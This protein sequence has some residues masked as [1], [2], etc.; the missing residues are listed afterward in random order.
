M[1]QSAISKMRAAKAV[2]FSGPFRRSMALVLLGLFSLLLAIGFIE[3]VEEHSSQDRAITKQALVSDAT[4][5][6]GFAALV[7]FGQSPPCN[8][9]GRE[10]WVAPD[11]DDS[12]W[13]A[14][15]VPHA[16]LRM[17]RDYD[18]ALSTGQVYYRLTIPI[19]A[20][21]LA[22]GQEI[23]F[24]PRYVVHDHFEIY[25]DGRLVFTGSGKTASGAAV[26]VPIA[27]QSI[28]NGTAKLAIKASLL[29]NDIG[30][31]HHAPMLIGPQSALSQL[32]TADQGAMHTFFLLFLLSKGSI[33]LIFALLYAFTR[34]GR[35]FGSFLLFAIA[36]TMEPL[37]AGDFM[38]PWTSSNVRALGFF[39]LRVVA[40]GALLHFFTVHF[41]NAK[42][43]RWGT[44]AAVC[45]LIGVTAAAADYAWGSHAATIAHL[46]FVTNTLYELVVGTGL[47]LS[48]VGWV[49]ATKDGKR[50]P[51]HLK[52]FTAFLSVYLAAITY[53]FYAADFDGF[54]K[55]ALYDLAFFYLMALNV[56]RDFGI[57]ER[58]IEQ[59]AEELA[60]ARV[61]QAVARTARMLAHDVRSPLA[62]LQMVLELMAMESNP[63]NLR[64]L[65]ARFLP[66]LRRKIALVDDMVADLLVATSESSLNKK[67][68]CIVELIEST[69]ADSLW[70]RPHVELKIGATLRHD[71]LVF[72]DALK[73]KRV[74]NNIIENAIEAADADG[75]IWIHSEDLDEGGQALL[76]LTIGNTGSFIEADARERVFDIFYTKGKTH[77]TG[78][79][80]AIAHKIVAQHGGQIWCTS[81]REAGTEFHLVLPRHGA[82]RQWT[83]AWPTTSRA[84]VAKHHGA[85]S[86]EGASVQDAEG[87]PQVLPASVRPKQDKVVASSRND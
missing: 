72:G 63:D 84:L 65:K 53:E 8:N 44:R 45:A 27:R 51:S 33:V 87:G 30:I 9:Q 7:S 80:L 66:G 70:I 32:G 29:P 34:K 46:F 11:W 25:V 57:D 86:C 12:T 24:S 79:G 61:D 1:P 43:R 58:L 83:A 16:S 81:S 5:L 28:H 82:K 77:G 71:H 73:I 78:L 60:R 2:R 21:L 6:P 36:S 26:T 14:W 85:L 54:S 20:D 35:A 22:S 59:Q 23:S 56:A 62:T 40:S 3:L 49:R 17:H 52:V 41:G 4:Q 38:M 50:W 18:A 55:L 75:R 15:D 69:L 13:T 48:A 19:P 37:L 39:I 64:K 67:P 10:C 31:E 47:A 42:M 76:K 68:F 74:L